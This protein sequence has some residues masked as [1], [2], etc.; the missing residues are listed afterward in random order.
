MLLGGSHAKNG[1]AMTNEEKFKGLRKEYERGVLEEASVKP[2]PIAQFREW[3]DLACAQS[4][5]AEANACA[6]ATVGSDLRPSVRMVLLKSLDERGFVF[7]TN[8]DSLKGRQISENGFGAML[9]YWESLERQVR[10]EGAF[11]VVSAA[12]SDS[13]FASRPRG[14]QIAAAA[15]SQSRAAASR[16]E[17]E[18]AWAELEH[19]SAGGVIQRPA[20]WGGYRLIPE[21][22]EFWQGR[23]SRL[24][25][26]IRFKRS[27]AGG[28]TVERLWP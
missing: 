15:S 22:V 28:W 7:F 10:I 19:T 25:D 20:N 11:E 23:E 8:Y 1:L 27:S 12:E 4:G 9:F 14:S 17:I 18:R 16:A 13:Y 3:F 6:V 2:C 24:H 5:E 21:N 26:R